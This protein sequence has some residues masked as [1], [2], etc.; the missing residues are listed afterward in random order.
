MR[1]YF[2]SDKGKIALGSGW[3]STDA[4][5]KISAHVMAVF[6]VLRDFQ[7][8]DLHPGHARRYPKTGGFR[9]QFFLNHYHYHYYCSLLR[10][11]IWCRINE[12]SSSTVFTV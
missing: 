11:I 1:R 4:V 8:E 5:V 10:P 12:R 3:T 2:A 9:K 6:T 7:R